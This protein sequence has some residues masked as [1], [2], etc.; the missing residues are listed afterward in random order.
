[1][2]IIWNNLIVKDDLSALELVILEGIDITNVILKVP[3][4]NY[5]L[6]WRR[7]IVLRVYEP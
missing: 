5:R 2:I 7:R 4:L 1:M 3:Y 6:S